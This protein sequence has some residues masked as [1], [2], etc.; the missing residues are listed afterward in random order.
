MN[1]KTHSLRNTTATLATAALMAATVGVVS[2][3]STT[4]DVASAST[5][6]DQ[7]HSA[8]RSREAIKFRN[9]MR[10]LWEDHIV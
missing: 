6:H 4:P 5:D 9:Q 7:N 1:A 2:Y 3:G 8:K 10:K